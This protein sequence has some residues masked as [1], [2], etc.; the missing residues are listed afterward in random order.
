[1]AG[2]LGG[3]NPNQFSNLANMGYGGAQGFAGQAQQLDP[4]MQQQRSQMQGLFGQQLG[5]VGQPTGFEGVTSQA[6]QLGQQQIGQQ[7]PSDIEAL[8]AQYGGLAG[9]ASLIVRIT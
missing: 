4:Y 2:Y 7:A 5:Q 3:F 6:L 9:Q 1:M 8:R